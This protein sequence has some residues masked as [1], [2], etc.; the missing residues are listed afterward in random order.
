MMYIGRKRLFSLVLAAVLAFGCLYIPAEAKTCGCGEVVRVWVDGFGNAVFQNPGTQEETR[1]PN[2]DTSQL[3]PDIFNILGAGLESLL[4]W[5]TGKFTDA[6]T[7]MLKNLLWTWEFNDDGTSANNIGR[8]WHI[9]EERNHTESP[10]YDFSYD[11]R[12]DPI[13]AAGQLND[14]IEKLCQVTGHRKIALIGHSEG[15]CV[16]LSYL[17]IYGSSRLETIILVNGAWQG[18]T[19]VGQLFTKKV[20]LVPEAITNFIADVQDGNETLQWVAD[21]LLGSGILDILPA[22]DSWWESEILPPMYSKA[23]GPIALKMPVMQSFVPIEDWPE[24]RKVLKALPG[25]KALLKLADRYHNDIQAKAGSILKKALRNGVKVA[26]TA[27][28][29]HAPIPVTADWDYQSD[30]FLSSK[31]ESGY[32]GFARYKGNELPP[33][34]AKYRSPDGMVDASTC[35]LPE[36]TWFVK[37][38]RHDSSPSRALREFIITSKTIPTVRT[39][40]DFPQYL[41]VTESGVEPLK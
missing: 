8:T 32:A 15:S 36:Y 25:T 37:N 41:I 20:T 7:Q 4:T 29:N 23:L 24:A 11:Y 26:I 27:S 13:T 3:F 39:S 19:L 38:Q 30:G 5:T 9:D 40:K 17:A 10:Q 31:H 28:Y 1:V 6:V 14:F 21:M 16:A 35:L 2:Q 22:L 33:S 34:P 12:I 18:V